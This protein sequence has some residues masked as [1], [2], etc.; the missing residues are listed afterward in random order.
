MG[1]TALWGPCYPECLFSFGPGAE[2]YWYRVEDGWPSGLRR[3]PGK[4]VGV[5]APRGFE[6]RPVRCVESFPPA[7]LVTRF[8]AMAFRPLRSR[9]AALVLLFAS[10]G[11]AGLAID[12]AHPCPEKAPW[13]VESEGHHHDQ[14]PAEQHACKCVGVCQTAV[15]GSIDTRDVLAVLAPVAIAS[16]AAIHFEI[17]PLGR[18][19]DRLPPATAPPTV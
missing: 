12:S 3:T 13:T 8:A 2:L 10:P 14:Q 1:V 18:P 11:F 9:F 4:R 7:V 6:S 15:A 19:R 5:Q 17:I 16:P